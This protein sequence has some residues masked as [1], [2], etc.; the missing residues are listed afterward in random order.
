MTPEE[1]EKLDA[2]LR[3]NG[4]IARDKWSEQAREL[5]AAA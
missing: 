4:R 1:A 5:M 2:D 3:F